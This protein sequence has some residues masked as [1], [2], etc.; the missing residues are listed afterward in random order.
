MCLSCICLLAMHTLVCVTFSHPPGVG[1]WLW[2]LFVALS[3]L[4]YLPFLKMF[5][6][7]NVFVRNREPTFSLGVCK[8]L[9][10]FCLA[11]GII[12]AAETKKVNRKEG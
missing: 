10:Y 8:S 12:R 5:I 3:G 7:Q 11:A 6:Q 1:G 9:S 4:F 2:L